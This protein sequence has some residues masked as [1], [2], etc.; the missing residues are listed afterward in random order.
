MA[1]DSVYSES[2]VGIGGSMGKKTN[3]RK[4]S[5]RKSNRMAMLTVVIVVACLALV[6]GLRVNDLKEQQEIYASRQSMID[7]Q[8]EYEKGRAKELEDYR[9]YVQSKQY[10]EATA[11]EKLGLVTPDEILLKPTD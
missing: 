6:L 11:K 8:I 5:D 1:G 4:T 3:N 2:F 7:E 9:V 10:I